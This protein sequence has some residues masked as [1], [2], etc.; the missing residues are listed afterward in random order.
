MKKPPREALKAYYREAGSWADD[1]NESLRQSRRWAWIVAACAT[2][3]AVAEA[4][5]LVVLTPLKTTVPY[6]LLVDRTTGYVETLSPLTPGQI[7]PDNALIQSMLV[8][9]VLAREGFDRATL[10]ADYR[11]VG[12][13]SE[14]QARADYVARMQPSNIDSPLSIYPPTTIVRARVKSVS[15]LDARSALV[16]FET[17]RQDRGGIATPAQPWVAVVQYGFSGEPLS[18]EDRYLNPL[19]FQ[20][21]AYRRDAEAPEPDPVASTPSRPYPMQVADE[22]SGEPQ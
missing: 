19:G 8:Q 7:T 15:P 16:R 13:W 18:V 1:R 2:A 6:T 3:V 4:M 22:A 9:Y 5:A 14:A 12:L 20:V 21:S 17:V 10:Q 11:R